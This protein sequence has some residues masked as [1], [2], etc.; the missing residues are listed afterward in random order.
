MPV[1]KPS[2][3]NPLTTYA[4]GIHPTLLTQ[5]R[6]VMSTVFRRQNR[7]YF[8]VHRSGLNVAQFSC[9]GLFQGRTWDWHTGQEVDAGRAQF[10][11][12]ALI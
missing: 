6:S 12:A 11:H 3:V 8:I 7:E 5:S 4:V 1:G 10:G 2:Q 9:G